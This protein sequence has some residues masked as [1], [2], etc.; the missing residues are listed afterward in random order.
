MARV[1]VT[2]TMKAGF[3][4]LAGSGRSFRIDQAGIVHLRDEK[5]LEAWRLLTLPAV[6]Q[7]VDEAD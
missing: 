4:G 5:V 3:A 7:Q 1:I 6:H 2:G